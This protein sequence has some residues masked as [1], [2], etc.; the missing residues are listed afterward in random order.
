MQDFEFTRSPWRCRHC[1][2]PIG[3]GQ[4]YYSVVRPHRGLLE[5]YEVLHEHWSQPPEDAIAWW[6][7]VRPAVAT[8]GRRPRNHADLWTELQSLALDRH[9]DELACALAWLLVR[10]KYL[11]VDA[12]GAQE[13]GGWVFRHLPSNTSLALPNALPSRERQQEVRAALDQLLWL[14][15]AT[16]DSALASGEVD[17]DVTDS[18]TWK[19]AA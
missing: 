5:R 7:G 3:P 6:R 11:Q 10:R 19:E 16:R 12:D 8:R 1:D 17:G 18:S 13:A 15:D 2:Q 4:S 14:D 9:Q